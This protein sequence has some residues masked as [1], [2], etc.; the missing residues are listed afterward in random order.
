M[1]AMSF[2][3][4]RAKVIVKE[5][6]KGKTKKFKW[7]ASQVFERALERIEKQK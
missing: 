1:N 6:K 4:E 2:K 7:F 5:F 3:P